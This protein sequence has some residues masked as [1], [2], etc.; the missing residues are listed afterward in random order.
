MSETSPR[1]TNSSPNLAR[2]L[3]MRM[4][5]KSV[6]SMPQPTAAPFTAVITGRS[7]SSTASA[8]GVGRGLTCRS[9]RAVSAAAGPAMISRTSSP[10]QKAGSVPVRITQRTSG[11]DWA[12]RKAA[13]S[14]AYASR[15]RAFRTCGRSSAMVATCSSTP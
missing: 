8:A 7:H 13:S 11:S 6:R 12:R 3:A 14:C 2:S 5:Q 15:L 10:L 1:L 9:R 4:S